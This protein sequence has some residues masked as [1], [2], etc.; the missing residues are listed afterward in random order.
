MTD[1]T[2]SGA[3]SQT[4]APE[5]APEA[6]PSHGRRGFPTAWVAAALVVG[7]LLGGLAGV[8]VPKL[9]RPGDTSAEAGFTRDMISHHS[10]AVTMAMIAYRSASDP[11]VRQV[12]MEIATAQQGEAGMMY[13][14]LKQWGLN[15][16]GSTRPMSWMPDG[17]ASIRNG[18][19]PGMATPEQLTQLRQATGAQV[20]PLFLQLMIN[21]HLG[22]VHML[23]A[24]LERAEDT[25]VREAATTMKNTQQND[26][27]NLQN[28][29][30]R[31]TH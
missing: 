21:H 31:F 2:H 24:V 16:T 18:L 20:D 22:G 29:Q 9:T 26:L 27:V 11:D 1:T 23:T 13:A 12:A 19:M 30:K 4:V 15:Y 17:A 25:T 3:A 7:M 28:L 6:A 8:L 5:P 10:Q 14:W